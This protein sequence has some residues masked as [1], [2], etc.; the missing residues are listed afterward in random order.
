LMSKTQATSA[1]KGG[2]P[3]VHHERAVR[4]LERFGTLCYDVV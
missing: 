2:E 3:A 1:F 4:A